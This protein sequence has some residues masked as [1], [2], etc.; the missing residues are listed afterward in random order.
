MLG[1]SLGESSNT[2][3]PPAA[4]PQQPPTIRPLQRP[5]AAKMQPRQLRPAH[6]HAQNEAPIYHNYHGERI[7]LV[8]A[9]TRSTMHLPSGRVIHVRRQSAF[10]NQPRPQIPMQSAPQYRVRGPSMTAQQ[11]TSTIRAMAPRPPIL[12][13]PTHQQYRGLPQLAP[14]SVRQPQ[15]MVRI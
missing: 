7:D 9:S 6:Q 12:R 11:I 3:G 4:A 2:T 10:P 1:H 5:A 13:Q 14:M 15:P 8:A